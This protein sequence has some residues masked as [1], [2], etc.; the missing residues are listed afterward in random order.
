L[1]ELPERSSEDFVAIR[2]L[3]RGEEWSMLGFGEWEVRS[4]RPVYRW[5]GDWPVVVWSTRVLMGQMSVGGADR[6]EAWSGLL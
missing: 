1:E 6:E 2:E 5:R 4:I 3:P